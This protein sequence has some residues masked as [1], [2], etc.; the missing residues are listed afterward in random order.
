MASRPKDLP[1]NACEIRVRA[2]GLNFRDV[3]NVMGLYPGDPGP[4]GGDCAGTVVRVGEDVKHL[5]V[6]DD[7]YGVAPGCLKT[8]ATTDAKL[9]AL[10]P[11]EWQT[12]FLF[13]QTIGL[14]LAMANNAYVFKVMVGDKVVATLTNRK[15]AM[16]YAINFNEGLGD[17]VSLA[18]VKYAH[19]YEPRKEYADH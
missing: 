19:I 11:N 7:V 18:Y 16:E 2:V 9:L 10:K 3:L 4:P 8:Y 12:S 5:K 13:R 17:G 1:P 6:G 15:T 14:H